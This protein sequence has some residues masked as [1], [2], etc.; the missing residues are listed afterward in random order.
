ML[1]EV[2]NNAFKITL[3]NRNVLSEIT[4]NFSNPSIS[5][6][7]RILNFITANQFIVRSDVDA[8]L[9]VSQSTSSRILKRMLENGMLLQV[10]TG[11]NTKYIR[12]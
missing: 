7:E 12:K 9:G 4:S 1:I 3:P 8:L 6:E 10:G 11:K 2:T 5:D